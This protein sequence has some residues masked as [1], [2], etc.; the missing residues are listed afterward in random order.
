MSLFYFYWGWRPGVGG[1]ALA[2]LREMLARRTAEFQALYGAPRPS[3]PDGAHQVRHTK[4]FVKRSNGLPHL[5]AFG[6][7]RLPQA[8]DIR[9]STICSRKAFGEP[10]ADIN[11]LTRSTP[12]GRGH[13]HI[14]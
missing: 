10:S 3:M 8:P 7:I 1:S 14:C 6:N 9:L 5:I 11:C 2:G 13:R 12:E 4:G